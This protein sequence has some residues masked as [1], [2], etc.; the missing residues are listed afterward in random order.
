M[1][2]GLFYVNTLLRSTTDRTRLSQDIHLDVTVTEI[3]HTSQVIY[4][5]TVPNDIHQFSESCI[6]FTEDTCWGTP[7]SAILRALGFIPG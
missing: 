4:K 7:F 5:L 1:K 2:H 6:K 3:P